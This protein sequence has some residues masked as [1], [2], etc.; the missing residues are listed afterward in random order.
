M[1]PAILLLMNEFK[2]YVIKRTKIYIFSH[3]LLNVHSSFNVQ[4][5]L[6]QFSLCFI[7]ILM[8]GT[9]SQIF[10]LVPGSYLCDSKM[11]LTKFRK[12]FPFFDM[13]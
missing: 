13:K 12:C 2:I 9:M 10:Y 6:L 3:H 8:E 5:R 7:D 1:V 4:D 11:I